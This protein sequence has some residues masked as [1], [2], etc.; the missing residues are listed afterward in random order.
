MSTY[1]LLRLFIVEAMQPVLGPHK[2][3]FEDLLNLRDDLDD[4]LINGT[5]SDEKYESEWEDL[6]RASGWTHAQ[7]DV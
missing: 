2:M 4:N 1:R 5:I 7:Y 3:P 6:L